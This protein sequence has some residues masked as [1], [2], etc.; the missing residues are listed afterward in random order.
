MT[1]EVM[2]PLRRNVDANHAESQAEDGR[3]VGRCR[4]RVLELAVVLR[5][6]IPGGKDEARNEETP[7]TGRVEEGR[8]PRERAIDA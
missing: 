2:Q 7:L 1:S 3:H 5:G 4:G 6:A 8:P